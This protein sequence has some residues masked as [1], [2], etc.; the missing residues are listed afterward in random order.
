[1]NEIGI[2]KKFIFAGLDVG[3]MATKAVLLSNG[4]ILA[5]RINP[6]GAD[7][8]AA[9]E[10]ALDKVLSDAGR[11][12]P[13]LSY[14]VG[15]GYGR[16]NLPFVNKTLTELTC[17]A[18]GAHFIHP[19]ARTVID[20]GG[21]DSKVILLDSNG[22]MVDF[23][24]NDKC[25]AGTGR[26]L[27]VMANALELSLDGL[28]SCALQSPKPCPIT[29]TCAVFAESEVISLLASGH[30]KTDVAAGLH[31]AI[32]NRVGT[33]ARRI[34]LNPEIV[35]AGGVAKNMAVRKAL[36]EFL[37]IQFLPTRFDPQLNGALGAAV[38]AE[39]FFGLQTEISSKGTIIPGNLP[40]N[41]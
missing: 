35:F 25:A 24:M 23:A 7:P 5:S 27:E 10:R 13:E 37:G 17:H 15:T 14:V 20:I 33:L 19:E 28:S 8:R 21:Q 2:S 6:T 30:T 3:S 40:G 38:L 39:E 4:S 29:N 31:L 1:M 36:E 9:G 16:I 11:S 18:K 41:R 22:N 32:A 34:G 12:Y 26:F